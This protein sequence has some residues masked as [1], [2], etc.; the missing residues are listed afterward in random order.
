MQI[1]TNTGGLAMTNCFLLADPASGQAVLFDA[2]DGTVLPL[3]EQAKARNWT[4]QGLWLT[5]G[6]FDHIADHEVVTAHFPGAKVLIHRLD[7]P[8]LQNPG[9]Q[10][11]WFQL[12]FSIPPRNADG[13]AQDQQQLFI[14]SIPVQVIHT[15]GHSPGHVSFH[16]PTE[17]VLVGGDLIIGGSIGRTDLPDS[18]HAELEKSVRRVMRLD[19]RTRLLP[20]HG[21]ISTLDWE[22]RN[23]PFVADIL[24]SSR[25]G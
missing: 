17:G 14:G 9:L 24:Q 1:L 12:P 6:H 15:P 25:M 16:L 13:Y 4:I 3:I 5:H 11:R 2:P 21:P 23:N 18:D 19:P 10:S 7:E 20:G 22:R 8:K